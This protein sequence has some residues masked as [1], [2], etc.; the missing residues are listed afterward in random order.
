MAKKR[1]TKE[2]PAPPTKPAPE[3]RPRPT[4][5]QRIFLIISAALLALWLIALAIMAIKLRQN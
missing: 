1:R 3:L 4:A 2:S 5:R